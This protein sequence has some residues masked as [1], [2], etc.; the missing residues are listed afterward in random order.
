MVGS[1]PF[2]SG[3]VLV[4]T[5]GFDET[6]KLLCSKRKDPCVMSEGKIRFD[7]C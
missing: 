4:N 6:G 7:L 5:L 2:P 3:E 1:V